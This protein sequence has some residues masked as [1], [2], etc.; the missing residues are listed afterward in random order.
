MHR[1]AFR[2][3][4]FLFACGTTAVTGACVSGCGSSKSATWNCTSPSGEV[5]SEGEFT[6]DEWK[7]TGEQQL[8]GFQSAC[9]GDAGD[10]C[11]CQ[12]VNVKCSGEA[13]D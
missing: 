5:L 8:F 13:N 9:E 12:Y 6:C 10:G 7:S 11:T 1:F 3:L 2:V 4:M